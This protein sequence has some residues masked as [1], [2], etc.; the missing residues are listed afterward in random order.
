MSYPLTQPGTLATTGLAPVGNVAHVFEL[1]LSY[2]AICRICEGSRSQHSF[3]ELI[4]AYLT[5]LVQ[6]Y[7]YISPVLNNRAQYWWG[8]MT[9]RERVLAHEILRVTGTEAW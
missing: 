2:P 6:A 9:E 5:A 8:Q 4:A 3:G 7:R 1:H